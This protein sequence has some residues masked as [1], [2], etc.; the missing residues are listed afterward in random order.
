MPSETPPPGWAKD[1][2]DEQ[3]WSAAVQREQALLTAHV[4]RRARITSPRVL[5]AALALECGTVCG[6]MS[7]A[8][9]KAAIAAMRELAEGAFHHTAE[10][11]ADLTAATASGEVH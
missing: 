11:L 9:P 6:A 1:T 8:N 10:S 7:H 3:A 5:A 4:N 2:A